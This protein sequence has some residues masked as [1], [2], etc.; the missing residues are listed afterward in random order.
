M[1]DNLSLDLLSKKLDFI[2]DKYQKKLNKISIIKIKKNKSK[3]Y[4]L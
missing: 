3:F 1:N 2:N 4:S